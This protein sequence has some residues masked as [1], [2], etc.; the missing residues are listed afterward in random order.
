MSETNQFRLLDHAIQINERQTDL[1]KK[2]YLEQFQ[3]NKVDNF[4]NSVQ[5]GH[6]R[7]LNQIKEKENI[8]IENYNDA[9]ASVSFFFNFQEPLY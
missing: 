4:A 8:M 6:L 2:R 5:Y 1:I 9:Y 7:H 3:Q